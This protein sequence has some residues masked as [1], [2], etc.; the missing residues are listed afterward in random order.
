M[1]EHQD[2]A[3]QSGEKKLLSFQFAQVFAD[4]QLT[5]YLH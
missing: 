3:I 4:L 2:L 1:T 5:I